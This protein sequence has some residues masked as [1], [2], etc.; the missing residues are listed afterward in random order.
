MEVAADI[1]GILIVLYIILYILMYIC[2]CKCYR[3]Y[4]S[5]ELKAAD[6]IDKH[7]MHPFANN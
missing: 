6:E 1:G 7:A 3:G 2:C 4:I 5:K